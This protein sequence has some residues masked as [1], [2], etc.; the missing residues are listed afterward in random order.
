MRKS[1]AAIAGAIL[2]LTLLTSVVSSPAGASHRKSKPKP[3]ITDIVAKSGGEFDSNTKDYDLLLNAV[4]AAGLAETLA[5][6]GLN[7]T[8]WAPNDGAFVKLAN[9]LGYAGRDEAGAFNAIVA[10]LTSLG[11]GDPI[12][13]LT[14]ILTYHVTPGARGVFSVLFTKSFPTLNGATITRDCRWGPNFFTLIDKEPGLKDPKLTFPL[15][16]K[17]SNGIIH[18]IDRVLIPVDLDAVPNP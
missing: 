11:G 2:A 8:V 12:P 6:P 15:Q 7:V 16:V 4:L 5:T 17:A 13:L 1:L 9:D 14:S 10:T 18:T 3:T